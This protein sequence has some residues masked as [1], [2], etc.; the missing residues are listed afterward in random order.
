MVLDIRKKSANEKSAFIAGLRQALSLIE[1]E[2]KNASESVIAA[3]SE[4]RSMSVEAGGARLDC[5]NELK[6]KLQ[7]AI[8]MAQAVD[9]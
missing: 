6:D 2:A 5:L 1:R 4:R 9:A 3:A 7:I 8:E